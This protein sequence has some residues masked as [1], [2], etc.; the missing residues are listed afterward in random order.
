MNTDNTHA[1]LMKQHKEINP[2]RNQARHMTD[3]LE[4]L[5]ITFCS[6]C[7]KPHNKRYS[8][9]GPAAF[10][11]MRRDGEDGLQTVC[12]DDPAEAL[13]FFSMLRRKVEDIDG[14]KPVQYVDL[15]GSVARW[16]LEAGAHQKAHPMHGLIESLMAGESNLD[17]ELFAEKLLYW[18]N[19]KFG[20]VLAGETNRGLLEMCGWYPT[21]AEYADIIGRCRKH[22]EKHGHADQVKHFAAV[23]LTS[24]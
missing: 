17:N 2:L 10:M 22:A 24:E 16:V 12:M 21:D 7:G 19:A 3:A 14:I 6:H 20:G 11:Y 8:E 5:G 18:R 23:C 15:E 13:C 4:M 1:M 9:G